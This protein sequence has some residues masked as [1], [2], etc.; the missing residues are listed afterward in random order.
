MGLK[1]Y[2]DELNMKKVKELQA[3]L[4]ALTKKT[5]NQS[6][7]PEY[8]IYKDKLGIE[9]DSALI[10]TLIK[11]AT[12]SKRLLGKSSP[13]LTEAQMS[14]IVNACNVRLEA[15]EA[16]NSSDATLTTAALK[17][18]SSTS[19]KERPDSP[20]TTVE[21]LSTD[22]SQDNDLT[23]KNAPM[24]SPGSTSSSSSSST[25]TSNTSGDTDDNVSVTTPSSTTTDSIVDKDNMSGSTPANTESTRPSVRP[26]SMNS[27]VQDRVN[28]LNKSKPT[29]TS[30]KLSSPK[31]LD[32]GLLDTIG[33]TMRKENTN[34]AP[35]PPKT[36]TPQ[37]DYTSADQDLLAAL[38]AYN[39][40][41][42]SN[43]K[44]FSDNKDLLDLLQ[45]M[46][47]QNL[48]QRDDN[49]STVL[50]LKTELSNS[51]LGITLDPFVFDKGDIKKILL[52]VTPPPPRSPLP[53][54]TTAITNMD[55]RSP[56]PPQGPPPPGP[57]EDDYTFLSA[58]LTLEKNAT[59]DN[60]TSY[61]NLRAATIAMIRD[62]NSDID[63]KISALGFESESKPT[64]IEIL[65][66]MNIRP[67]PPAPRVAPAPQT[68]ELK[69]HVES[70][71]NS[72]GEDVFDKD[73]IKKN[74]NPVPPPP[75]Q[76]PPPPGPSTDADYKLLSELLSLKAG[77]TD[78]FNDYSNIPNTTIDTLRHNKPDIKQKISD[79]GFDS[80]DK[81]TGL[82]IL[83][84][85]KI[86]P[87]PPAP[88]V[89]PAPRKVSSNQDGPKDNGRVNFISTTLF[90][91][92]TL[93]LN[94]LWVATL[95]GL[96]GIIP[97][98]HIIRRDPALD[99]TDSSLLDAKQNNTLPQ[100]QTL[101]QRQEL[102][103]DQSFKQPPPPPPRV[104]NSDN[105]PKL[106][107]PQPT[108]NPKK[109][110]APERLKLPF[111]A[112]ALGDGKDALRKT[113]PQQRKLDDTRSE[114]QKRILDRGR[115]MKYDSDSDDEY[116][117]DD[118]L[119][120]RDNSNTPEKT[121]PTSKNPGLNTASL[122][123]SMIGNIHP[124]SRQTSTSSTS[125]DD[126]EWEVDDK[127]GSSNKRDDKPG[128]SNKRDDKPGS[129]N[130]R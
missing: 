26:S 97:R 74:L 70:L 38:Q 101:D 31:K 77:S 2:I 109:M 52:R 57:T 107:G 46:H 71:F 103:S 51:G 93:L 94:I 128:S 88:R 62:N 41:K 102:A 114:Q 48:S 61:S 111:D 59:T 120:K 12:Q 92:F 121:E 9:H 36:K 113:K 23:T 53:D 75:P 117:S 16:L 87:T 86:R 116:G 19:E 119:F 17:Q 1:D 130:N 85:M 29:V 63:K 91:P 80:E 125:S 66:K 122:L 79:L 81:P 78:K 108:E 100:D 129:R 3:L 32:L 60:F 42:N 68:D 22:D 55:T 67:T 30:K 39:S 20:T 69:Q 15:L 106:V 5:G 44:N 54:T 99:P 58:L 127:P 25:L 64:G 90:L 118:E 7:Q 49:N 40:N 104:Y 35:N 65:Q 115:F 27:S 123:S 72:Q 33:K 110:N 21:T 28:A 112:H 50:K 43:R 8:K 95:G 89:A 82:E 56:T 13:Y 73:I 76:G 11:H 124:D 37:R 126:D 98:L 14:E 84:K 83:Q 4:D 45:Y 105:T 6:K 47:L 96:F 24:A 34:A 18:H 10:N